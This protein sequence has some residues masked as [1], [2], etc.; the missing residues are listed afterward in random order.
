MRWFT[1]KRENLKGLECTNPYKS[2]YVLRLSP[3]SKNLEVQIDS[4]DEH[5]DYDTRYVSIRLEYQP[6][7]ADIKNYL[8]SLQK[9]YDKCSEVNSFYLNDERTWFDKATRVGLANS[10][11]IQKANGA[12]DTTLWVNGTPVSITIDKATAL[13]NAVELYAIQ[14]NDVTNRHLSE[15]DQLATIDEALAYDITK[16]YPQPLK[17]ES[18]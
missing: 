7:L 9:E 13:L 5:I 11:A 12:T 15:I 4:Q 18:K 10:L 14:C 1:I 3:N 6:V 2:I 17:I 16:D 8:V